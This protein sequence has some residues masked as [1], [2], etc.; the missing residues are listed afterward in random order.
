MEHRTNCEF[1]V[2]SGRLEVLC[3]CGLEAKTHMDA[4]ISR[5]GRSVGILGLLIGVILADVLFINFGKFR[6]LE[7]IS[8]TLIFFIGGLLP[9]WIF[10][11]WIA[12]SVWKERWYSNFWKGAFLSLGTLAWMTVTLTLVRGCYRYITFHEKIFGDLIDFLIFFMLF[13]GVPS[14][15][16]GFVTMFVMWL[17]IRKIES[18]KV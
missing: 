4:K 7:I 15:L 2:S 3:S 17:K 9:V 10:T 12:Q 13:G 14:L 16:I 1:S 18:V 8:F 11:P 6:F 5:L